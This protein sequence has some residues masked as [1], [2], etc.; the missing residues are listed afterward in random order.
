[1]Y[2][3]ALFIMKELYT[4]KKL[5][6]SKQNGIEMLGASD[7]FASMDYAVQQLAESL[8]RCKEV[9]SGNENTT[10]GHDTTVLTNA[11][12]KFENETNK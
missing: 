4:S 12:V 10:E 5:K 2:A 8:V 1:M 7:G 9:F 11:T 3:D 6:L